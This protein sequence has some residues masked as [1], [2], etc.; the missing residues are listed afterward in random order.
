MAH[1]DW[2]IDL[3]PGAGNDGGRIV[4]EGTPA[5][6]VAARSTL[7]GEHLAAYVAAGQA[8]RDERH[9]Q[10]DVR[11]RQRA[12][13]RLRGRRQRRD[14]EH[15]AL[16][17]RV[18]DEALDAQAAAPQPAR[19][20]REVA[21][22]EARRGGERRA[23]HDGQLDRPRLREPA[24]EH[25]ERPPAEREDGVGVQRPAE[26]LEV[27][28]HHQGD[29]DEHER[30]QGDADRAHAPEPDG[31]GGGE[32]DGA[33]R[34]ERGSGEAGTERPAV[35][36]V[37]AVRGDADGQEEGHQRPGQ[38]GAV[39]LLREPRAERDVGEM[40]GRVGR[41]QQRDDVS[42]AAGPQGVERDALARHRTARTPQATRP[43]PRLISRVFTFAAPASISSSR[44]SAGGWASSKAVMLG[45]R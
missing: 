12:Q 19:P 43:P 34:G 8:Q 27:V 11:G 28:G 3:G 1:A 37:E 23:E 18:L 29:A 39:D 22:G 20:V 14:V 33:G 17:A 13:R 6:L 2:I 7:T 25:G 15:L 40:P 30:Q 32:R 24:D 36:L 44:S 42:H 31:R 21:L 38:A 35:E 26:Q 16:L 41:V 45:R 4:F 10:Q 9:G 5:D